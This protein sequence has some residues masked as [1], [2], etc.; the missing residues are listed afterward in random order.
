[1]LLA[2]R[3]VS[4]TESELSLASNG[5]SD[6]QDESILLKDRL[7]WRMGTKFNIK[8]GSKELEIV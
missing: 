2:G 4:V 3:F 7:P 6:S 8:I 1:L 5:R